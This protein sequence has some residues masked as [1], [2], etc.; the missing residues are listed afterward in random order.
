MHV[1]EPTRYQRPAEQRRKRSYTLITLLVV[2]AVAT[3]N[4]ARPLPTPVA[5]LNLS[6]PVNTTAPTL[7][8]PAQGQ[9]A[10]AADG[11]GQLGTY[12]AMTPL[13]TASIAKVIVALCVLQKQP[14]TP[15]QSGP[16][17]TIGPKDVALYQKY[18]AEDGSLIAVTDGE[19]LTEYQA[20]EALMIPSANNIA[21]SL[22]HWV[23]GSQA[24]YAAY[25]A[26]FLQQHGLSH[27]HIGPD[28]S[29]YDPGTTSTAS[30]L[31]NL[32][33]IALKSPVLLEIAG[34]RTTTLPVVGTVW[35][36]DTILGVNG[37]TG[38]KTGNND[39]DLGAFLF[40]ATAQ[41]GDTTIPLTGA[42]MDA[43]DL[44]TAL[45]NST[46]LAGSLAKGF[47]Q[48]TLASAGQ[49][50]GT[51]RAAWGNTAEIVS[52]QDLQTVRWKATPLHE[53]HHLDAH[54]RKGKIGTVK[55]TAGRAQ[56]STT[57]S[58]KRPLAG[59]SFWWRLTRH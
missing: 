15:G 56:A 35:N 29:G 6:L 22:V 39:T 50:V 51:L 17:Y 52:D 37:I 59:P 46:Q 5:T 10:V 13:S 31:T 53:T 33:L 12:G 18:L 54:V 28:A 48:V 16:T 58:L 26:S 9:A 32:G 57:L 45:H 3:I 38:L 47:E 25:A 23:F 42:V 1:I 2:L 21:D 11:Y 24:A 41:I 30:D 49:N 40:T 20:L 44:A 27:T 14:L 7:A 55:V 43:P 8:W 4:Y 34:K 36:Y 19:Q